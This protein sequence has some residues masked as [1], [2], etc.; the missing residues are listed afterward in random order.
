MQIGLEESIASFQKAVVKD[1]YPDNCA[2]KKSSPGV[3]G[4]EAD[5][6]LPNF[7]T[8]LAF[9]AHRATMELPRDLH[10]EA[11]APEADGSAASPH[12]QLL[13]WTSK[14]TT[15]S[16]AIHELSAIHPE[17][18]T[19]TKP[20]HGKSSYTLNF[21]DMEA[22]VEHRNLFDTPAPSSRP[23][24]G[25]R[26]PLL[27]SS[28]V[29]PHDFFGN[30]SGKDVSTASPDKSLSSQSSI[31]STANGFASE[32]SVVGALTGDPAAAGL[33]PASMNATN[34]SAKKLKSKL[35]EM[36]AKNREMQS[37]LGM[38]LQHTSQSLNVSIQKN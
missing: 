35:Q 9:M 13:H 8:S 23:F 14:K 28:R 26:A 6:E 24:A 37:M 17:T 18:F 4:V 34:E 11:F 2:S 15:G 38:L 29:I 10:G 19:A 31:V 12:L 36:D 20:T 33:P 27:N 3:H 21:P 5:C 1:S 25:G 30:L 16:P 7:R 32:Q 22:S